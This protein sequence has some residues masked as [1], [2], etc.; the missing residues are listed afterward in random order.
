MGARQREDGQE[1][2]EAARRANYDRN[3]QIPAA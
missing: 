2:T 3:A 1:D